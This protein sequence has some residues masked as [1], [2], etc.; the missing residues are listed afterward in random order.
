MKF[1]EHYS[2]DLLTAARFWRRMRIHFAA[3]IGLFIATIIIGVGGFMLS[4]LG[5][6]D[7]LLDS[8]MLMSGMGPVN[9]DK[10]GNTGKLFASFYALFCG[11]VFVAAM[12]IALAPLLHRLLHTTLHERRHSPRSHGSK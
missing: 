10:I 12:G 6:I 7:A 3:A 9:C 2:E 1:Y 5:F 8:T 4:G 11:I